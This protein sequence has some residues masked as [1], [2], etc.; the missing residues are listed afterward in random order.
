MI[1]AS[2]T[3]RTVMDGWVVNCYSTWRG[4][5]LRSAGVCARHARARK[6]LPVCHSISR[7]DVKPFFPGA[8]ASS[9]LQPFP[10]ANP[11]ATSVTPAF[12]ILLV[13]QYLRLL[14]RKRPAVICSGPVVTQFHTGVSA[15]VSTLSCLSLPLLYLLL[16][17]CVWMAQCAL[18]NPICIHLLVFWKWTDNFLNGALR[19]HGNHNHIHHVFHDEGWEDNDIQS[20]WSHVRF[21]YLLLIRFLHFNGAAIGYWGFVLAMVKLIRRTR[22]QMLNPS[23]CRETKDCSHFN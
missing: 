23:I 11:A 5:P 6:R 4:L 17:L 18:F 1:T 13:E 15:V 20:N 9:S 21:F 7:L 12:C 8:W 14:S 19:Y 22:Y 16:F 3:R 2:I 10:F